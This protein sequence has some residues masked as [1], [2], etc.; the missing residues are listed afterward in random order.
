MKLLIFISLVIFSF[1][2]FAEQEPPAEYPAPSR[3]PASEG[4]EGVE[5]PIGKDKRG[6]FIYDKNSKKKK[7]KTIDGVEKP[8]EVDEDGVYYYNDDVKPKSNSMSG[9]EKPEDK[10]DD[11]S[12]YYKEDSKPK[13]A[14]VKYGPKPVKVNSDGSYMY[15]EQVSKTTNNLYFRAGAMTAPQIKP[16]ADGGLGYEDVYGDSSQ[17]VFLLEYDWILAANLYLKASSGITFADGEGQFA[18]GANPGINPKETFQFYAFPT[19]I[20]LHY[21]LGF[22]DLQWLTPYV[23]AGPGYFG[24]ME[25]RSDGD[26]TKFGGAPVLAGAAGVLIS[27]T[28]FNDGTTMA[29]DYG[30]NQTWIDLQFKQILGIDSRKDFTSSLI[31]LGFAV[32]F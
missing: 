12:Y 9:V 26:A 3:R 17:F 30:I 7:S 21:R 32:G 11:G 31:T 23:E 25:I 18:N 6:G 19:T 8:I 14:N 24:F 2:V 15:N 10:D 28:A 20:N 29:S 16:V 22:W 5:K 1:T 13:K 27:L 4:I